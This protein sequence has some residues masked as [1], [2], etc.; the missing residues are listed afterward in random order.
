MSSAG[1]DYGDISA[2][3]NTMSNVSP[4]VIVAV[5]ASRCLNPTGGEKDLVPSDCFSLLPG[6][7]IY[8]GDAVANEMT[9]LM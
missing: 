1:I 7:C 9:C 5:L 2:V 6:K 8:S 3:I 4:T